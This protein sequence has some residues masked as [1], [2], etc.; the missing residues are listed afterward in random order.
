MRESFIFYKTFYE[1]IKELPKKSGYALYNAIF[2]YVFSGE[3]PELSGIEKGIF[4]LMKEK[5]DANNKK[6]ENFNLLVTRFIYL[7]LNNNWN[8]FIYFYCIY[9]G[10]LMHVPDA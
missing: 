4:V 5:I 2:E 9:D 1:C 3:E 10:S 6:Y 8:T 7:F